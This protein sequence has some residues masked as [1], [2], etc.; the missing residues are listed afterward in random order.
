MTKIAHQSN[1]L[2][3]VTFLRNDSDL[4]EVTVSKDLIVIKLSNHQ[5]CHF[6]KSSGA[7]MSE[8][9]R[10]EEQIFTEVLCK[11]KQKSPTK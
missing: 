9:I 4:V 6:S 11:F 5:N 2:Q 10:L 3:A 7:L 8:H 1:K